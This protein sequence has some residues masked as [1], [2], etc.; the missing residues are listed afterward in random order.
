MKKY[1]FMAL[2][3][4]LWMASCTDDS[5]LPGKGGNVTTGDGLKVNVALRLPGTDVVSYANDPYEI[6][7][8]PEI[9]VD[10]LDIYVF[11]QKVTGTGDYVLQK[12]YKENQD[13]TAQNMGDKKNLS[14]NVYGEGE[15][16]MYFVANDSVGIT[17]LMNTD[18]DVTKETD[19]RKLLTDKKPLVLP[20]LMTSYATVD[21]STA[22]SGTLT[23]GDIVL[24]R[25]AARIDIE[26]WEQT[27]AIDSV[28]LLNT[29]EQG[30]IVA[31]TSSAS[32]NLVWNFA[33]V[34]RYDM[35]VRKV[36][37]AYRF[38]PRT[39]T[40]FADNDSVY[41][42]SLYYPYETDCS[43]DITKMKIWGRLNAQDD[44]NGGVRVVY[45]IPL[46]QTTGNSADPSQKRLLRN[47]RYVVR[48]NNVLSGNVDYTFKVKDWNYEEGDTIKR[49]INPGTITL[50]WGEETAWEKTTKTLTAPADYAASA[51]DTTYIVKVKAETEWKAEFVPEFASTDWITI[52][53][54][55]DGKLGTQ[56]TLQVAKNETADDRV[57]MIKV[58]SQA[59]KGI[60][61][62]F[63]VK[64]PKKN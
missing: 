6:A 8:T 46:D 59:D 43:T 56:F 9:R 34:G 51:T 3:A 16:H 27:L 24:D 14:I 63:T 17:S 25:L 62:T 15:I 61:Y 53:N 58:V 55:E 60:Y 57:S 44:L 28:Q 45:E 42:A 41:L 35:P 4:L 2:M 22:T 54:P 5:N 19:F 30:Y 29:P 31:D 23:I 21:L 7:T 38:A 52:G 20:M 33:T 12:V 1:C 11:Y 49:P 32:G 39:S 37:D 64:Q 47:H 13:F 40:A 10:S 48:I 50:D 26:N 36:D 18:L